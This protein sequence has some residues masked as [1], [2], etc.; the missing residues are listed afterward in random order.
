MLDKYSS[1]LGTAMRNDLALGLVVLLL[2]PSPVKDLVTEG[3]S[4][5]Q[6]CTSLP[7]L[8]A[9]TEKKSLGLCY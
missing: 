4:A 7:E 6:Y 5:L 3:V 9:K 1:V 8:L 2:A